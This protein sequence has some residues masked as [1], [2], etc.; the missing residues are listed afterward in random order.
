M[1]KRSRLTPH[2]R[3]QTPPETSAQDVAGASASNRHRV[4]VIFQ[5]AQQVL[6]PRQ[7]KAIDAAHKGLV[8]LMNQVREEPV[9][10]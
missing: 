6:I 5:G 3:R 1:A 4:C 9:L 7:L 8:T 10:P 2:G